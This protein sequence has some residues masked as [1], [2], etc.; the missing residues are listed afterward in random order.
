LPPPEPPVSIK[1]RGPKA[2]SKKRPLEESIPDSR[3]PSAGRGRKKQNKGEEDSDSAVVDVPV[4]PK[5]P[6][7]QDWDKFITTVRT[8]NEKKNKMGVKDRW[9]LLGWDNG[10]I[11]R[12]RLPLLHEKAPQSMLKFYES[13]L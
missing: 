10:Q 6:P 5:Y 12:H 7:A 11:T 2:G 1:K 13:N 4:I 8:I 3:R 9:G